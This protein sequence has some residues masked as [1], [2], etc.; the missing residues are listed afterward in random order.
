V[1]ED[2]RFKITLIALLVGMKLVRLPTL[3][4]TGYKASWPALKNNTLDAAI[5][6]GCSIVW[7]SALIL[8]LGFPRYIA[9]CNMGLPDWL[10]WAAAGV[11][12][13]ALVLL[14]WADHTLGSNLSIT[15]EIKQ[16]HTLVTTGPYRWVRHP[17]YSAALL[18]FAALAAVSDNW[19]LAI[20]FIGGLVV[21]YATRI[22]R[23]EKMLAEKFGDRYRRYS[24]R[25]ARLLPWIW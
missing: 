22:P 24:K 8:Y 6:Y 17:I 15:L 16:N 3:R 11:A 19:L 1:N 23:E 21:L 7:L 2:L 5:L 9:V 4:L 25:T 14:R 10:R 20:C 12:L 13:A 18:F